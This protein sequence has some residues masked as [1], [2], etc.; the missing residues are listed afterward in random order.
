[1]YQSYG[2]AMRGKRAWRYRRLSSTARCSVSALSPVRMGSTGGLLSACG[3]MLM[4]ASS[5]DSANVPLAFHSERRRQR[6]IDQRPRFGLNAPQML[7][8]GEA[9]GVQL[10]DVFRAGGPCCEPAVRGDHL[11][12]ADGSPV[13][14]R[15]HEHGADRIAGK[16]RGAD[17]G[18]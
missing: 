3:V 9:L 15:I 2:V 18:G 8:A 1:M 4:A 5:S 10:V 16:L 7:P 13:A 14:G 17:V 6:G 12:T 11:E